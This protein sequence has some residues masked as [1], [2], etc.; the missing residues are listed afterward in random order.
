[1]HYDRFLVQLDRDVLQPLLLPHLDL[2]ELALLKSLLLNLAPNLLLLRHQ[3]L[4]DL[5]RRVHQLVHFSLPRRSQIAVLHKKLQVLRRV[6]LL[7]QYIDLG[8]VA[9][10]GDLELLNVLLHAQVLLLL[11]R[12]MTGQQR[13]VIE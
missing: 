3:L 2:S 13:W 7:R 6:D 8:L 10:D 4:I 11:G 5:L 1:M 12:P 9:I